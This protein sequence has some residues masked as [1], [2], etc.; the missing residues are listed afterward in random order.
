MLG[1]LEVDPE[2]KI[3]CASGLFRRCYQEK[4]TQ[5]KERRKPS[6]AVT[7]EKVLCRVT[8]TLSHMISGT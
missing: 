2:M 7:S 5:D 3:S 8:S 4:V 1:S 6:M